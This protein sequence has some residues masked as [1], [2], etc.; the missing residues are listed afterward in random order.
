[1]DEL[2]IEIFDYLY[3]ER[4][5]KS[6]DEIAGD[7]NQDRDLVMQAIEHEWFNIIGAKIGISRGDA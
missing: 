5:P 7:L 2:R 6:V 1:M 3:R 4:E